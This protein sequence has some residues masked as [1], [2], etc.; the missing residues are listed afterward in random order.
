MSFADET[1]VVFYDL[2]SDQNPSNTIVWA[3]KQGSFLSTKA[4]WNSFTW[5]VFGFRTKKNQ[6]L[7]LVRLKFSPFYDAN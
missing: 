3:P 7:E 1:H 2:Y 6:T 4:K 5:C